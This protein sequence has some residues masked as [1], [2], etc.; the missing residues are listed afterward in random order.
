MT[1]KTPF[2]LMH[3][4]VAKTKLYTLGSKASSKFQKIQR[5][6]RSK[7]AKY[8]A[9]HDHKQGVK[10]PDI[11]PGDFVKIRNPR[12]V[13]KGEMR[14][15]PPQKVVSVKGL[16]I[17]LENGKKWNVV[18][19]SLEHTKADSELDLTFIDLNMESQLE[20]TRPN[21]QEAPPVQE[22]V[23]RSARERQPLV[24][25][26]LRLFC[27]KITQSTFHIRVHFILSPV[28]NVFLKKGDMLNCALRTS[29]R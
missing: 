26:M 6:V 25:L 15:G 12:H 18:T 13:D 7:Q 8:K 17:I 14:Y 27:V 3:G 24:S 22:P 21:I 28:T 23:R 1:E 2:E 9:Y 5:L 19:S 16:C 29:E 4:R 10:I 20:L 11:K